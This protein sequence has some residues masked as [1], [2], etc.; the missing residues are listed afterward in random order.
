[1]SVR[2]IGPH[3]LANDEAGHPLCRIATIFP[4][5]DV[6][7]TL[8]G[9]HAT[10]RL[11]FLDILARER[12]EQGLRPLSRREEEELSDGTGDVIREDNYLLIRPDPR[13]VSAALAADDVLQR[14]VPKWRI[15]FLHTR[16][17]AVHSAIKQRGECWRTA[18]EPTSIDQ[19][20]R[21][22]LSSRKAING[23]V[24]YFHSRTTGTHLLSYEQY[25]RLADLDDDALRF[26]LAE[27]QTYS[28]RSTR[29]GY[30]EVGFFGT[31]SP[32]KP[33]FTSHDFTKMDRRALR[34]AYREFQESFSRSVPADLREDQATN[35]AWRSRMYS[36]L[37]AP[38]EGPVPEETRLGLSPEFVM[39]IRWLPGGR[40]EGT[41]LIWDSVFEQ[42]AAD[43]A[44]RICDPL[45][46]G[47]LLNTFR[48]Y[49][50]LEYV[51]FGRVTQSLSCRSNTPGRRGVYIAQIKRRSHPE[52]FVKLIRMQK[53][54]VARR[55]DQDKDLLQSMLE[56]EE[57]TEYI[58]DRW[59]GCRQ[60]GMRLPVDLSA[61]KVSETYMGKQA[62]YRGLRIWNTYFERQYVRGI[63]TNKLPA[64]RFS[65]PTF[66]LKFARLLGRAAAI[67]MIVGR[68]DPSLNP[69][70]D[71]GDEILLEGQDRMPKGIMVADH[72]G[73]FADFLTPLT[74]WAEQ[75][76]RP[77][78]RR[79]DHVDDLDAFA[80]A[81]FEAFIDTFRNT[82]EDYRRRRRAFDT[83][84]QH[85]PHKEAGSFPHRWKK[86]LHRLNTTEPDEL[87]E[88]LRA[89]VAMQVA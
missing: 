48:E 71:D 80:S 88:T 62:R 49:H 7:V 45:V 75:Y 60:L 4:D 53:W 59:L 28:Q 22:I 9:I 63:A 64:C 38:R 3:P 8:P 65:A 17:S 43:E 68:C 30:P 1:M 81:Y 24:I 47:F 21:L 15:R 23:E 6:I 39:Q 19:M 29:L 34:E 12:K 51:N 27:L 57:Y 67:N 31:S 89:A 25:C 83:L 76:V 66:A 61:N 82:Q 5:Q 84:F 26:H 37:A 41:D 14:I 78:R 85:R 73:A 52:E 44:P 54:G 77:I 58:L 42:V 18:P 87:E 13:N 2:I 56:A 69:L 50:D 35:P 11:D 33:P 36:E 10:Q 70:F 86:I 46:T 32:L 79:G 20:E 74:T 55:L 72:T 40:I 16:E